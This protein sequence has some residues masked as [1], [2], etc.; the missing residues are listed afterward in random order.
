MAALGQ[1]ARARLHVDAAAQDAALARTPRQAAGARPRVDVDLRR[2]HPGGSVTVTV[3][4]TADL[5][6]FAVPGLRARQV[7]GRSVVAVDTFIG[8]P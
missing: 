7:S 6:V 2:L 8:A 1:L 4:C 3:T 5:G